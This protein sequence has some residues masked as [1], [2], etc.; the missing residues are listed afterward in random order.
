MRVGIRDIEREQR[1]NADT[2]VA[3]D[4]AV[5][6]IAQHRRREPHEHEDEP[7][8]EDE[9]IEALGRQAVVVH[10]HLRRSTADTTRRRAAR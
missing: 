3:G 1:G 8:H 9:R 2:S 7:G 4:E 6:P 5:A 10:V